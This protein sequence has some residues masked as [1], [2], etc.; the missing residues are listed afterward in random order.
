[1]I[2]NAAR[3]VRRWPLHYGRG[4]AADLDRPD[5]VRAGSGLALWH[6]QLAV[7]QD[8]TLFVGLVDLAQLGA[9]PPAVTALPLPAG[10]QGVRHFGGERPNKRFKPDLEAA[11]ALPDGRLLA[12]GSGSTPLRQVWYLVDAPTEPVGETKPVGVTRVDASAIYAKI[13][14]VPDALT[15]ELNLEGVALW[16]DRL[17]LAQRSNGTPLGPRPR[18]DALLSAVFAEVLQWLDHGGPVPEW[19]LERTVSLGYLDGVRLTLTDLCAC[20]DRLWWLAAAEDSPDAYQDGAVAGSVL[21]WL[22][23][24]G[25]HTIPLCDQHGAPLRSKCEGLAVDPS[26]PRRLWAVVDCDDAAV[27]AEL[28]EIALT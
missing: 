20:G 1:M 21:G 5:H 7:V 10:E 22:E 4:A 14:V 19:R 24:G 11:V 8:D 6:G 26:D 3:V 9:G 25:L 17:W 15:A 12:I 13:R 18:E 28:L 16:R 27:A 23:E 2:R